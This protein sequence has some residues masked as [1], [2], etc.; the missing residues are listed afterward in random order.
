MTTVKFEL[1]GVQKVLEELKRTQENM[2]IAAG[3]AMYLEG[4]NVMTEAKQNAPV[5][6]GPLRD[7]GY[8]TLPE[9]AQDG[10]MTVELGFGG[11]AKDYAVRQHEELT[12][13]HEVG[14]P[15][16][17]ENAQHNASPERMRAFFLQLLAQGSGK[18]QIPRMGPV[19]PK[20]GVHPRVKKKSL[21]K[22]KAWFDTL[23]AQVH[24]AQGK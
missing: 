23:K 17:L 12:W 2:A 4:W 16:F 10:R 13:R 1:K 18:P 24:K 3:G 20:E 22:R 5:D 8:V 11:I 14:G 6:M 21:Q 19:K 15:K 9:R 7:S